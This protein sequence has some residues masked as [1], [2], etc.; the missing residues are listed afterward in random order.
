MNYIQYCQSGR[1]MEYTFPIFQAV[2]H[3]TWDKEEQDPLFIDLS[4]ESVQ[5]VQH[6]KNDSA[7]LANN[8]IEKKP[9]TYP[10]A[11]KQFYAENPNAR[12]SDN[13]TT[14]DKITT[15]YT[16]KDGK[17]MAGPLD[18]YNDTDTVIPDRH[19]YVGKI[20]EVIRSGN[21]MKGVNT[22]NDT[23]DLKMGPKYT[24]AD[25][26]G[27][28]IYAAYPNDSIIQLINTNLKENPKYPIL[29][30]GGRYSWYNLL[31]NYKEYTKNDFPRNPQDLYAW[32]IRIKKQGGPIKIKEENK[33]KFTRS[34]KQA[35]KSVQEHARDV[36]N[37]PNSTELQ[38]KRAQFA[39]NAKKFKH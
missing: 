2:K 16:I 38:R 8:F 27:D 15:Y 26:N 32:G 34:A 23:V 31:G 24:F 19:K 21:K 9:G 29:T 11:T 10:I 18:S 12:I 22:D 13:G 39:I 25:E 5:K 7:I 30:D 28:A 17:L 36:V 33:G 20:Q 6:D 3:K 37:N 4:K 14:A 35:G 1:I